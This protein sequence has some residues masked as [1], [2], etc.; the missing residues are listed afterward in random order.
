M[1]SSGARWSGWRGD[2]RRVDVRGH[3]LLAR[4]YYRGAQGRGDLVLPV[5]ETAVFV[6]CRAGDS[7]SVVAYA[8]SPTRAALKFGVREAINHLEAALSGQIRSQFVGNIDAAIRQLEL[9]KR[10]ALREGL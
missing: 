1:R 5:G 3:R 7:M 4:I 6:L 10:K 8:D 2:G 9:A